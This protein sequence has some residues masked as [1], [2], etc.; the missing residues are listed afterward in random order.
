V[1]RRMRDCEVKVPGPGG[2]IIFGASGDL[3]QR[4]II[5]CVYRLQRNGFL[6]EHFFI[7]GTSRT[8]MSPDQFREKMRSAVKE[9][10]PREFDESNWKEFAATLYYA[11]VD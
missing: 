1:Y 8:E 7:L 3:T 4:K 2:L 6:P 11:P 10:F 9:A 5:P